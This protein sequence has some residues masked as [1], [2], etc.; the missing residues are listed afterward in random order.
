[1][2][3]FIFTVV[4]GFL[5]WWVYTRVGAGLAWLMILG[6][7]LA[8]CACC[9]RHDATGGDWRPGDFNYRGWLACMQRCWRQTLVLMFSLFVLGVLVAWFTTGMF[10]P[11]ADLANI[12]LAAVGAPLFVRAICCAYES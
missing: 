8:V 3:Q 11:A 9:C 2:L 10:P 6:S 7:V 5:W 1:M 4:F 12:L